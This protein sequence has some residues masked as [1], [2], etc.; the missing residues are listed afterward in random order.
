MAEVPPPDL[1]YDF[2]AIITPFPLLP[3]D[4]TLPLHFSQL[5][6]WP[7]CCIDSAPSCCGP[8]H[9]TLTVCAAPLTPCIWMFGLYRQPYMVS[10]DMYELSMSCDYRQI[11]LVHLALLSPN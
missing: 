4:L 8:P 3:T 9:S 10:D 6:M 11:L 1:N 2:I 7:E 5:N